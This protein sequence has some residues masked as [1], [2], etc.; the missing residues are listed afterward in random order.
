MARRNYDYT[1]VDCHGCRYRYKRRNLLDGKCP[2]CGVWGCS[3][4]VENA[5]IAGP[6]VKWE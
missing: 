6:G 2:K 5:M 1:P 3:E 4:V